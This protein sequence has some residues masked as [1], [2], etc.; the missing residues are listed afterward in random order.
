MINNILAR[1]LDPLQ[2][3]GFRLTLFA[4]ALSL[5]GIP[6]A[7]LILQV[8]RKT[9]LVEWDT[10]LSDRLFA[11]KLENAWTSKLFN[12]ISFLGFPPLLWLIVGGICFYLFRTG[13][14]RLALYMGATSAG[15]VI[16]TVV[17]LAVDRPRP[18]FRDPAAITFQSGQSFPSGHVMSTTVVYG[19]IL[20]I[21]LPLVA[22]R[23][24]K[25][26]VALTLGLVMII[27][28]ARLGLGV[29]YL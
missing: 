16:N 23:W 25:A 4:V 5:I 9:W 24:R 12:A 20:L 19:A 8:S 13:R 17:K 22:K 26:V 21:F 18:E 11:M 1:R 15:V 27:G 10:A 7:W 6:F 29:H 3:Y 2:R 14:K 28:V